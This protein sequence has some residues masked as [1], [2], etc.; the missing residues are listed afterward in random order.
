MRVANGINGTQMQVA[1]DGMEAKNGRSPEEIKSAFDSK[2]KSNNIYAG[3]FNLGKDKVAEERRKAREIAQSL[4]DNVK[5][6]DAEQLK[7]MSDR[8]DHAK[9]L[10]ELN[11]ETEKM[12]S[13]IAKELKELKE[14]DTS[15]PEVE[16]RIAELEIGLAEYQDQNEQEKKE[17]LSEYAVV[18]GMKQERLKHHDMI[19]A[20]EQA[21]DILEAAEKNVIGILMEETKDK[22]DQDAKDLKEKAEDKKAEEDLQEAKI[23][24][25]RERREEADDRIKEDTKDLVELQQ[26]Q[27][28]IQ[29]QQTDS[30]LPDMK[31]TMEQVVA[32]LQVAAE[33]LKGLIVDK[34]L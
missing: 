14:G 12:I 31:N 30:N 29:K 26:E 19:D 10:R 21:E 15:D 23:E 24:A 2:K 25:A 7:E 17:I 22:I 1:V 28:K 13:D 11:Q 9:E 6:K 18:R 34:E 32:E 4:V 8:V 20:K 5:K 33:D 3:D 27:D 16:K